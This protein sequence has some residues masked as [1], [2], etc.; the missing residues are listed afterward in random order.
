M[1][2]YNLWTLLL[3]VPF[4]VAVNDMLMTF[5]ESSS[6]PLE[7]DISFLIDNQ[8]LHACHSNSDSLIFINLFV[9]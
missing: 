3:C 7:G 1:L 4:L 6:L 5:E 8:Y 2:N 9:L